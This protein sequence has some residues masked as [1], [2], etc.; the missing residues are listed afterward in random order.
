MNSLFLGL[1][2]FFP[3][4]FLAYVMSE[5]LNAIHQSRVGKAIHGTDF[6]QQSWR[7]M[8]AELKNEKDRRLFAVY[9]L[10]YLV[11]FFLNLDIEAVFFIYLILNGLILALISPIDLDRVEKRIEADR[12]QMSFLLA[13]TLAIIS[14]F[15]CFMHSGSTSLAQVNW[16]PIYLV[17]LPLFTVAGMILFGEY[18]FALTGRHSRWIDS[19]RFYIWCALATQ[20]FLGGGQYGVDLHLKAGSL[21]IGFRLVA[22]YFPRYTQKDVF[23]LSVIYFVPTAVVLWLLTMVI[24]GIWVSG[25]LGV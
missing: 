14:A 3:I 12:T 13:S 8:F 21:F 7:D 23:R 15:V 19:A 20:L 24:H 25:G 16:S 10:Q 22:Q 11:V 4:S 17:F 1:L 5:R 9:V 6:L 18:P 2:C